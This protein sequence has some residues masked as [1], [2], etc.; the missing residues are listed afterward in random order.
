MVKKMRLVA[1]YCEWRYNDPRKQKKLQKGPGTVVYLDQ[2]SGHM[3]YTYMNIIELY[4]KNLYTL[5]HYVFSK[6]SYLPQR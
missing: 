5:L 2:G 4:T 3:D 6:I 1:T